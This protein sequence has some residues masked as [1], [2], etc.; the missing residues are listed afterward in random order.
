MSNNGPGVFALKRNEKQQ[1]CLID[2]DTPAELS[3]LQ[4]PNSHFHRKSTKISIKM[5]YVYYGENLNTTMSSS[6]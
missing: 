1:W 6:M 2:A 3:V 4:G 5:G